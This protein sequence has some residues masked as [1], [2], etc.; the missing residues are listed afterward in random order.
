ML[1]GE[2][3][4]EEVK[5]AAGSAMPLDQPIEVALRGRD[6]LSG[7]PREILVSDSQIREALSRS[8]KV[9]V[10]HMKSILEITPPELVADTY[11]LGIVITGGGAML[12][13]LDRLISEHTGLP[14]RVADD[15]LTTVVRGCGVLLDDPKLLEDVSLPATDRV[16]N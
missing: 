1:V 4:A 16:R 2:R 11:R 7:L 6:L 9:I 14:V 5:I 15:P 12:R 8:I 3:V 13:G 10:E